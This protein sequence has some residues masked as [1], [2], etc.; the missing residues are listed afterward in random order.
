VALRLLH[1]ATSAAGVLWSYE[2]LP[3]RLRRARVQQRV[4]CPQCAGHITD[5]DVSRYIAPECAA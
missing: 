3:G 5:T 2:A 4:G 1:G